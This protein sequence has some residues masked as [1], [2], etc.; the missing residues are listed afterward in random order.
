[1]PVETG[2]GRRK[3][4]LAVEFVTLF[5]GVIVLYAAFLRGVSPLPFLLVVAVAVVVYL[6]RTGFDRRSLWRAT[7]LR[8]ALPSMLGL[9]AVAA[10]GLGVAVALTR[11]DSLFELP[12]ERPLI[13]LLVLAFY[14]LVSVYPQELLFRAFLFHRYAPL[15][16]DGTRM[17]AASAAAFGVAHLIFGS[18]LSVVL[19]AAAG[20]LF[21]QRYRRTRSLLTVSVEHALYGCLVFTIGLGDFFYHGAATG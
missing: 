14:P 3:S 10:V 15:F 12:R 5:L 6:R 2:S 4:W 11:P 13:W 16:G 9:W 18:W 19:S 1:M 21:A 20:W 8:A 17:V 7:V